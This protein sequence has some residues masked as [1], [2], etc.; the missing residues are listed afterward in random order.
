[1]PIA[2]RFSE[3]LSSK[4]NLQP[5]E[6][7]APSEWSGTGNT[8]GALALRLGALSLNQIDAILQHQQ[9]NPKLFGEIGIQ[10]GYLKP[11]FVQRLIDLQRLHLDLELGELLVLSGRIDTGKLMELMIEFQ[12]R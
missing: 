1:M 9:S 5:E 11:E 6:Y 12:K 3:F 10:L 7:P 2:T 8:I 4:L